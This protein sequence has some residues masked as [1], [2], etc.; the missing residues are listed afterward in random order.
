MFSQILFL[1]ISGFFI[2]NIQP[3]QAQFLGT[4]KWTMTRNYSR[5]KTTTITPDTCNCTKL[6]VLERRGVFKQ[7]V[8]DELVD[9]SH[10]DIEAVQFMDDPISFQF[11]SKSLKGT[12]QLL[13]NNKMG[14]GLFGGCGPI[15]Y[16][17]RK[18]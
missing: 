8:N 3:D 6:L 13:A 15:S 2:E 14:I 10:Y 4:W 11:R 5:A 17:I 9:S 18:E 12:I 16:Y 1:L 7:Y